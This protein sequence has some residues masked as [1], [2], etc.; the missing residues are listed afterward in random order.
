MTMSTADTYDARGD[1]LDSLPLQHRPSSATSSRH[2]RSRTGGP[3]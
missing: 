2:P 3:A 1:E